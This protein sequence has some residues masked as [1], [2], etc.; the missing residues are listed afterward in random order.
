MERKYIKTFEQF[1]D[2]SNAGKF[3]TVHE[4]GCVMLALPVDSDSWKKLQ[5]MIDEDDIYDEEGYGRENETHVTLLYGLHEDIDDDE[6]KEAMQGMV[7]TKPI[8]QLQTLS[9]FENEKF[10]VLK[11][12]IECDDL[13]KMNETLCKFPHTNDYPDYHPHCTVAYLKP[14][15][16]KKYS[17]PIDFPMEVKP[18]EVLYSKPNGD[19]LKWPL[20]K[21]EDE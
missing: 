13:H 15:R 11:F 6:I 10:D 19:K 5:E 7:F 20:K 8:I 9:L 17:G 12:D 16:G 3:M 4:Y 18:V 21:K 1:V 14:G 2:E